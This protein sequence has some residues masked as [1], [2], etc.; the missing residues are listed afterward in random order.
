MDSGKL[1][2]SAGRV[3]ELP[4]RNIWDVINDL[5]LDFK[6]RY[7][8]F[9]G[10]YRYRSYKYKTRKDIEMGLLQFLC[11]PSKASVDIGANLG[12]FTYYLARFSPM[13]YAFEPNPYPYRILQYVIDKNVKLEQ[14]AITDISG[15]V[16]LVIPRTSKG[17]SS[18][19][20]SLEQHKRKGNYIIVKVPGYRLDD[21]DLG[22]IGFIKIDTEGH[23]LAVLR[24]AQ[25]TIETHRPNLF[26]EVE[27]SHLREK[28][29]VVFALLNDLNYDGF[30]LMDGVLTNI[31][32][33]STSKF[34][35]KAALAKSGHRYIKD[36]IFLPR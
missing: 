22:E 34:Q 35:D 4:N 9:R 3:G 8:P 10:Y 11:S 5:T 14:V 7:V 25:K 23:E 19:G 2:Q 24:G 26:V 21:L 32:N 33:F 31:S 30:F 20:A 36:F 13:V 15:E 29:P 16:E 1:T 6:F 18:N 12:L 27:Y 28:D 17:W